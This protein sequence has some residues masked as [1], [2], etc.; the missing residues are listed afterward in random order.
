MTVRLLQTT[1]LSPVLDKALDDAFT[2]SRLW[3]EHDVD[4][5]LLSQGRGIEAIATSAPVGASGE[6]IRALPDLKVISCRGVGLDKIDLACARERGI[7]VA[8][9]FG[10]LA[11]CVADLAFGLLI[12]VARRISVADGFV[13]RGQWAQ[14]KFPLAR[15]VSGKRLGIVGLGQIGRAIAQRARG[16]GMEIRYHNRRPAQDAAYAFE[17]DL[18]AL[19]RWADF[20]V[21]SVAGGPDTRGLISAPILEA[22]GPE[23]YLIN[24]SRGSVVDE[25]ALVHA[26][27][28]RAIAGAGLDVFQDEPRV[29]EAL[30]A[31]DNVVL[32]PHIASG[33]EETR[34]D[35]EQLVLT[36][37][38]R[39][40]ETGAVLTPAG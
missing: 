23:G 13:R 1:A 22:L 33:T 4:G 25:G 7:Q 6:L 16:F 34:A 39:F 35:M 5:F 40:F 9:T 14:D 2:V 31:L 32:T 36:N 38:T 28:T 19:S 21:V 17:P 26:L 24:V 3:L 27:Q 30:W 10:V 12:D 18:A 20:L 8:G 29:P 37:L 11:D 15:R